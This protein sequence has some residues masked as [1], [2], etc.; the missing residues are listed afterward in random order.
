MIKRERYISKIRPFYNCDLI[1]AITGVRRC[2]KSVILEQIMDEIKTTTDNIIYLN[3]E[4]TTDLL[5]ADTSLKLV[6][7]IK[8]NR[9]EG[10]C[11]IFLDEIKEVRDW[12]FAVKD[13]RLNNNS[14][15]ITGSN[16]KLFYF[17]KF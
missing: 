17:V 12:Q 7:Y 1:K 6:D 9:K 16:S 10:K 2:G 5:K 13:F 3:F 4:K 8:Q 14:I 15:F 11:Y